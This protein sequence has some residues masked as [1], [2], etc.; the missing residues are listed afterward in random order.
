VC[1]GNIYRSRMA[2]AYCLSKGIPGIRATSSGIAAGRDG[3]AAISPLAADILGRNGLASY[4]AANWQRTTE[5]LIRASDVLV[6]LESEHRQF[7]EAWIERG[8]HRVEVW[9]IEDIGPMDI[10]KIPEK[11]ERTFAMIRER[12]DAL[13]NNL[14]SGRTK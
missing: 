8:R 6:F 1:T 4:A 9:E 3:N 10:G 7:C 11:V 12:T 14:D 2:E 5:A 13:L